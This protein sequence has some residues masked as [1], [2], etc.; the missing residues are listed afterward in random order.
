MRRPNASTSSQL[1]NSTTDFGSVGPCV[2]HMMK[3]M[4]CRSQKPYFG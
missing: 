3:R 4:T 1:V 2:I